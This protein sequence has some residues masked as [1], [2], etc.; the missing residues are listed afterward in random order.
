[1]H[2]RHLSTEAMSAE[3][4]MMDPYSNRVKKFDTR[5]HSHNLVGAPVHVFG[6]IPQLL[7]KMQKKDELSN[8]RSR[9]SLGP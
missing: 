8:S 5:R 3:V 4:S 2:S 6:R 1:M 7:E 9:S